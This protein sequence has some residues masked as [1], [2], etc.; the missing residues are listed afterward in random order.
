[1]SLIAFAGE[2]LLKATSELKDSGRIGAIARC[3]GD[4]R[5][6]IIADIHLH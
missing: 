6:L 3:L 2:L 5:W 1:M 4:A